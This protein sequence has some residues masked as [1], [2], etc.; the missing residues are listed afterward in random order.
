MCSYLTLCTKI[1]ISTHISLKELAELII[2]LT[3]CKNEIKFEERSQ[4][5]FVRNRIGCP[6]KAENEIN[7]K[8]KLQLKEGLK[9]LIEWRSNHKLELDSRR[10]ASI[11]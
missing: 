8:A 7:F 3:G 2:E 9:K 6:K 4:S 1:S 10:Q 5:T 11:K